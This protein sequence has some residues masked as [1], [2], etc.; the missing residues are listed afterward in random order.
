MIKK[1][2]L[3]VKIMLCFFGF[4]VFLAIWAIASSM[5]MTKTLKEAEKNPNKE[6]V[7]N[8]IESWTRIILSVNNHPDTWKKLREGW[9]RI[10]GSDKVP[11]PMKKEVLRIF[12]K[13]GLYLSNE[14]IID[15]YSL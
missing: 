2:P 7:G 10:N 12:K 8:L 1:I 6:T 11:T 4:P 5:E 3:P 14:K 13:K 15:N 9:Y